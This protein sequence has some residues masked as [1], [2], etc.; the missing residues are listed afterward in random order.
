MTT[1]YRTRRTPRPTVYPGTRRTGPHL[2]SYTSRAGISTSSTTRRRRLIRSFTTGCW[3]KDT[4]TLS[5]LRCATDRVMGSRAARDAPRR[6][7]LCPSRLASAGH[8]AHS[9]IRVSTSS[10]TAVDADVAPRETDRVEKSDPPWGSWG[11]EKMQ[12]QQAPGWICYVSAQMTIQNTRQ[13]ANHAW[14]DKGQAGD[15]ISI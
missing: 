2:R 4:Q 5:C 6:R 8:H 3:K 13:R 15:E 10:A 9:V 1:R 7:R 11:H 12:K 14:R